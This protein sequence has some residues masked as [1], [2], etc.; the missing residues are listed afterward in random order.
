MM[1][2]ALLEKKQ[3]GTPFDSILES[4]SAALSRFA[5]NTSRM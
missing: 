3:Q 4:T 5:A 2:S 1:A